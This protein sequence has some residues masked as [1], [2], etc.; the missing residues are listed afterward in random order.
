MA[1]PDPLEASG[2]RQLIRDLAAMAAMLHTELTSQLDP[3]ALPG[4]NRQ[5]FNDQQARELVKE[6][7][8]PMMLRLQRKRASDALRAATRTR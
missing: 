6:A 5:V 8:G 2:D 1:N 7:I 3:T 4:T